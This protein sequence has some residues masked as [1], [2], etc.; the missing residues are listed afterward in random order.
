MWTPDVYQGSPTPVTAFMSVGAKAGG[1]AALLR[2]FVVAF[3]AL[4]ADLTPILWALAALTMFLGNVVA[5]A[6][7]N[8][9]RLLAYSSI[10]HAGYILMA[11]VPFGQASV[12]GDAVARPYS[13]WSPTAWLPLA[14]GR[15]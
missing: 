7:T 3:P 13:T 4:G 8:I 14:P 5:I 1:F 15:W 11:I 2:I 12:S 9:K 10:A 6:Q